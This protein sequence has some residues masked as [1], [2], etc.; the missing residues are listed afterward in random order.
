MS[1]FRH[2]NQITENTRS[3]KNYSTNDIESRSYFIVNDP[4]R[5]QKPNFQFPAI[6]SEGMPFFKK[7]EVGYRNGSRGTSHM[8]MVSLL[9][10]LWNV[11]I[12]IRRAFTL[13]Q[14]SQHVFTSGV[15]VTRS[16]VRRW[17]TCVQ[18]IVDIE[19]IVSQIYNSINVNNQSS[20]E[21]LKS[22]KALA[23]IESDL[24]YVVKTIHITRLCC[25]QRWP[26]V[27]KM[28]LCNEKIV[29]ERWNCIAWSDSFNLTMSVRNVFDA[30]RISIFSCSSLNMSNISYNTN[31]T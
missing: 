13:L 21:R 29:I 1:P 4:P 24:M 18:I 25:I 2:P 30:R 15:S 8:T 10:P 14:I 27:S 3:I 28:L 7:V 22:S 17:T 20:L 23:K 9:F 5:F 31:I 12:F 6:L 19:K 16:E 11:W 26:L